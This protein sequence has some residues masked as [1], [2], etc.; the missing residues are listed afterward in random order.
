VL[1]ALQRT[2]GNQ[3]V[4]RLVTAA[5]VQRGKVGYYGVDEYREERKLL[6]GKTTEL[7]T[8]AKLNAALTN[9]GD[10]DLLGVQTHGRFYGDKTATNTVQWRMNGANAAGWVDADAFVADLAARGINNALGRRFTLNIVSCFTAGTREQWTVPALIKDFDL[11]T[12]FGYRVAHLLWQ[13]GFRVG[14]TIVAYI[15]QSKMV[16]GWD[17][18]VGQG[19]GN[20]P[21]EETSP[22]HW[23][24]DATTIKPGWEVTFTLAADGVQTRLGAA[25]AATPYGQKFK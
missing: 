17:T 19:G 23:D 3:A 24:A 9:L 20:I 16:Q 2:S 4:Q 5:V 8:D 18:V 14:A 1:V 21:D 22:G 6:A 11:R 10:T 7:K 25:A 13:A 12:T 15:G